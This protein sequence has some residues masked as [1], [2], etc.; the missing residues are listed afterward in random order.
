[1]SKQKLKH[2]RRKLKTPEEYY[3]EALH[4]LD[5]AKD[6]LKEVKIEHNRYKDGKK[7][8]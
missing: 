2:A 7:V 5:N 3:K 1:M 4:Y 8:R 6:I